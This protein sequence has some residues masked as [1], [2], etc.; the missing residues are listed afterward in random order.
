[1]EGVKE[2]LQ[3]PPRVDSS[4]PGSILAA[5][6]QQPKTEQ[7][8]T[9][10]SD[11]LGGGI[12]EQLLALN[13]AAREATLETFRDKA[14][15]YGH[16]V[17]KMFAGPW[18]FLKYRF[19][20]PEKKSQFAMWLQ[21]S[22]PKQYHMTYESVSSLPTDSESRFVLHASDL[23]FSDLCSTK[24]PPFLRTSLSLFDE[25][26]TRG[27]IT[28]GDEVLLW[29]GQVRL[30][31]DAIFWTSFVKGAA[32]CGTLLFLLALVKEAGWEL[33]VLHPRLFE[34]CCGIHCRMDATCLDLQAVGY[35]NATLSQAGSLR[36]AHDIPTWLM[37]M[38]L[39]QKSGLSSDEAIKRWNTT[40]SKESQLGGSKRVCLLNLLQ[41]PEEACTILLSHASRHGSSSAFAE[42][43]FS[44]KQILPGHTPRLGVKAWSQRLAITR[45]SFVLMMHFVDAQHQEKLPALRY[46][47]TKEALLEAAQMSAL[48]LSVTDELKEKH[49]VASD[50]VKSQFLKDDR[51][52]IGELHVAL[53]EKASSWEVGQLSIIKQILQEHNMS[54]EKHHPQ[55][56]RSIRAAELEKEEFNLMMATWEL[57]T[58]TDRLGNIWRQHSHRH[59]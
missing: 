9:E 14:Y 49:G 5:I 23:G 25:I 58:C 50:K 16:A 55:S 8:K 18:Q 36:K 47:L 22:F 46:K 40:A 34:S 17:L 15:A 32:R 20:T 6:I 30:E 57:L 53:H 3:T 43:A 52:L 10:S 28:A 7:I 24:P 37:K 13:A 38:K 41:C 54:V 2:E 51:H 21:S 59:L 27:F 44:Q 39:F 19:D 26:I 29:R 56:E 35:K 31:E 45:E 42:D 33:S 1:M 4:P 11:I 12:D 48:V